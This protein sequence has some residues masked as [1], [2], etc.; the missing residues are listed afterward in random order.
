M[1]S[2]LLVFV[3][4]TLAITVSAQNSKVDNSINTGSIQIEVID[5]SGKPLEASGKLESTT[6]ALTRVFQT[7]QQ[8]RYTFTNLSYGRYK[9]EVSRN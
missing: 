9:L 1:K 5:P 3:L 4:L 8:G 2:R 7:D 6:H